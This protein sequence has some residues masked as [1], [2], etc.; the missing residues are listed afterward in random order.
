LLDTARPRAGQSALVLVGAFLTDLGVTLTQTLV[1]GTEAQAVKTMIGTLK[2]VLPKDGWVITT[3]AGI[4]ERDLARKIRKADGHYFMR[5]K[6]R[7]CPLGA[8]YGQEKST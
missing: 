8:S 6:K 3:D 1:V 7:P 5:L 4:T 2:T